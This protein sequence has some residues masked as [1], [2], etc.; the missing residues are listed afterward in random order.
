MCDGRV[1]CTV[2]QDDEKLCT[3]HKIGC[4]PGCT[5]F[6][7]SLACPNLKLTADDLTATDG[8]RQTTDHE[9]R[10]YV[11]RNNSLDEVTT[12]MNLKRY[13]RLYRFDLSDNEITGFDFN[14][15]STMVALKELFLH[16]NQ[17]TSITR[18]NFR[19]CHNL[20]Y[21]TLHDN[22]MSVL[23]G[24][25]FLG[26][27]MLRSIKLS[28]MTIHTVD[29]YVFTDLLG[30]QSIDI[31]HNK[32]DIL[33]NGTFQM[34]YETESGRLT[35]PQRIKSLQ[36]LDVRGNPLKEIH[37][38]AFSFLPESTFLVSDKFKYCCL[39]RHLK[40][41]LPD[42]DEF[43]SCDHLLAS[44]PLRV[45]TWAIGILS[46]AS[47]LII[48]QQRMK[49]E[50]ETTP[51]ILIQ[52]LSFA[53]MLTGIY[54]LIIAGADEYWRGNY[55][56]NHDLWL[57]HA[58]C[59]LAAFLST[60]STEM[61]NLVLLLIV[62]DRLKACVP[63]YNAR[64]LGLRG[65]R[66]IIALGWIGF[67]IMSV[68]PVL[69]LDYF[70]GK[71][72]YV[73]TGVCS[74]LVITRGKVQGW[75]FAAIVFVGFNLFAFV[76]MAIGYAFVFKSALSGLDI[77][78]P[79][80]PEEME[81]EEKE[82]EI[83]FRK[84]EM[85]ISRRLALVVGADFML[86][87]PVLVVGI[88]AN[89]DIPPSKVTAAWIQMFVIPLCAAINPFMYTYTQKPY[90]PKQ[91]DLLLNWEPEP[92]EEEDDLGLDETGG[93]SSVALSKLEAYQEKVLREML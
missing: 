37:L 69:E 65:A 79:T 77:W 31:S 36:H 10:L 24:S 16:N 62:W 6:G 50:E 23:T 68:V 15:F 8:S 93:D 45:S 80:F 43:S 32:I 63:T 72:G 56:L 7:K 34:R 92:E 44:L 12:G 73:S 5:C 11:L 46:F 75:E 13:K 88:M 14:A 9:I 57:E 71:K 53:N 78:Y 22:P 90:H 49:H 64:G 35:T 70:G 74:Q 67:V 3:L 20:T 60:L 84:N 54:M 86:W 40:R 47:N 38:D 4:P 59:K 61:A 48:F 21:L 25:P 33:K 17:L 58:L 87:M 26:L 89:M 18:E 19:N 85:I 27:W 83:Q 2:H 82:K 81:E 42:P 28:G 55:I 91:D 76:Y 1:D 66:G 29:E 30:I 39:A 41:C 52:H 51:S